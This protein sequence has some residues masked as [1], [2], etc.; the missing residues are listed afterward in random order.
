[1]AQWKRT[2]IKKP[3]TEQQHGYYI[4]YN[5]LDPTSIYIERHPLYGDTIA[6]F[7][8]IPD[9]LTFFGERRSNDAV[10]GTA[11]LTTLQ[12]ENKPIVLIESKTTRKPIPLL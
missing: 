6:V 8:N 12:L 2:Y 1:M 4:L 10:P 9:A 7:T 5:L 3:T 11:R